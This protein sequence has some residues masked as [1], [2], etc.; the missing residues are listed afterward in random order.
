MSSMRASESP[1][2]RASLSHAGR[3]AFPGLGL[4]DALQTL[5]LVERL[6]WDSEFF[7]VPIATLHPRRLTEGILRFAL[8]TQELKK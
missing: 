3:Q 2:A 6:E 5:T 8:E 7:G 4:R 1:A